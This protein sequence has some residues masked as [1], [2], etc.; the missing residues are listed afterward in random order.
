MEESDRLEGREI[1]FIACGGPRTSVYMTPHNTHSNVC[2]GASDIKR[3]A[4]SL[5]NTKYLTNVFSGY[6]VL[7]NIPMSM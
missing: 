5:L 6:I 3:L 1:W 4:Q 2:L 7:M